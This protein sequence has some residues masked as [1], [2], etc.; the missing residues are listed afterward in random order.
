MAA[1]ERAARAQH[2]AEAHRGLSLARL[3][4]LPLEDACHAWPLPLR[5][6]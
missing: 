4:A 5:W 1:A 6:P 3:R 2:R